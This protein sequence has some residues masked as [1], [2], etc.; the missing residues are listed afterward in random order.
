MK[1]TGNAFD[2]EEIYSGFELIY[3]AFV[4]R[5][6]AELGEFFIKETQDLLHQLCHDFE[7]RL[8]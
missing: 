4:R 7:K 8:T 2:S 6:K 5:N 3:K 1:D